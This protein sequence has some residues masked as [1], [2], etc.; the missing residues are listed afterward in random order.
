V[1]RW[2]LRILVCLLLG[3]I[4]TV[5][6]AWG[7]PALTWYEDVDIDEVPEGTF[8]L[9]DALMERHGLVFEEG[10]LAEPD[11]LRALG[12]EMHRIYA[13]IIDDDGQHHNALL[14]HVRAGWP[15]PSATGTIVGLRI[16]RDRL[17]ADL[18]TFTAI[19]FDAHEVISNYPGFFPYGI[20]WP[21]F[22]IDTLFYAAIWGGV[23][24]G[25][26]SA[27][28]GIRR[29]LGRCPQCGDDLRG[30]LATGCSECGWNRQGTE[31]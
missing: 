1:K 10:W 11:M 18:Q 17:G 14:T 31:A 21:G 8:H 13:I 19:P 30:D 15:K 29:A 16:A 27:K 24:F 28:R 2:T 5:A 26:A 3:A 22:G 9:W 20:I 12:A 4:T 7:V 6:V 23:F 25:F